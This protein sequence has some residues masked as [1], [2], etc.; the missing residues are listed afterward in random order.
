MA[1]AGDVRQTYTASERVAAMLDALNL[2]ICQC[3]AQ[4]EQCFRVV[5][6]GQQYCLPCTPPR[7]YHGPGGRHGYQGSPR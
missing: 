5:P 4:G 2:P 3:R 7:A 6:E 1:G